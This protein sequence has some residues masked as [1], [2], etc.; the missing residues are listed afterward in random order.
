[1]SER[2]FDGDSHP[3]APPPPPLPHPVCERGVINSPNMKGDHSAPHGDKLVAGGV[4]G[5]GGVAKRR[6]QWRKES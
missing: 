5:G 2:T 3:T 6:T 4:G 1:M